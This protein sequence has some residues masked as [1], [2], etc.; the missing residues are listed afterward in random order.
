MRARQVS[1]C[2]TGHR[3]EK[4][5]WQYNEADPRCVSVKRRI[6]DAVESAYREGFCHFLCGMALG[7]DQYFCECVLALREVHPDV[8]LEA[9]IPC[10]TQADAWP[11]KQRERYR[12]LVAACDAETM[13]STHYTPYCMLRRDRYMVDHAS[14]VIAVFDG[15]P[16][17]T[18]YTMEY[19]MGKGIAVVDLP[20][21][22]MNGMGGRK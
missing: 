4:L 14:L 3:P 15:T 9:V 11:P 13:V 21:V 20:V 2:F 17:G 10:P 16:G 8:T 5:P 12:R 6:M 1:C 19:A 22:L 18:R 7:C